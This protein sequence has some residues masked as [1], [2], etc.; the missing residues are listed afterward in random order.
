MCSDP[1]TYL[2][3]RESARRVIPHYGFCADCTPEYQQRMIVE[4][5]CEHPETLFE[6]DSDG[7]IGGTLKKGARA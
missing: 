4:K 5:K 1:E 3:W 2:L 7:F 6:I